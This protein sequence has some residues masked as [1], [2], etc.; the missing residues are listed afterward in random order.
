VPVVERAAYPFG[1]GVHVIA[2]GETLGG[3]YAL[4]R[5]TAMTKMEEGRTPKEAD[6]CNDVSRKSGSF[7]RF[8]FEKLTLSSL[9]LHL[10]ILKST[11]LNLCSCKQCPGHSHRISFSRGAHEA[12][13]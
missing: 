2:P 13:A 11:R 10:L 1:H 7:A 6:T 9:F 12:V 3:R 4:P 5:D 8:I